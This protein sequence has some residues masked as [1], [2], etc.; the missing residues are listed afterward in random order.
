MKIFKNNLVKRKLV[1]L[2]LSI[3]FG[4]LCVHLANGSSEQSLWGTAL[5]W[6]ILYNRLLIGILVTI[7]GVFNWHSFFGMSLSP[8]FRG[9]L[10]GALVSVDLAIGVYIS[11]DVPVD[12][13]KMIFWSTIIAGAIYGMIIDIVATKVAGDGKTLVEGWAK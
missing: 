8:W 13:I 3:L 6:Q 2:T 11:S 12:Q 5:M 7:M 4:L 10:A 9:L 1:A